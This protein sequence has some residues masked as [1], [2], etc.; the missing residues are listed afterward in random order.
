MEDP[1][2]ER[3]RRHVHQGLLALLVVG[4]AYGKAGLNQIEEL[5]ED[6][7]VGTRRKLKLPRAVSDSTLWRLL[8]RQSVAGLRETLRGW[9]LGLLERG[10]CEPMLPLGVVAPGGCASAVP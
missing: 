6:L 3:G 7:G 2:E 8:K 4:F 10:A 5:S 1:R 9:G